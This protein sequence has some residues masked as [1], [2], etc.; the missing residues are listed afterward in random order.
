MRIPDFLRMNDWNIRKFSVVVLSLFVAYDGAFLTNE[1]LFKV[2]I[3]PQ[4]L[5]FIVLTFIPGF[6]ILRILKVHSIDRTTN[7]LLAVGLS[8]SF[9]MI[10]G[11]ILNQFLPYL[12]IEKPITTYPLFYSFN[13]AIVALL[14]ISYF[15]DRNFRGE[16]QASFE[17]D[18]SPS[19]L[20]L[21]LLP[22]LGIF[23][24]YFM[25]FYN[26]N[27]I[28]LFLLLLIS[29]IPLLVA[30]NKISENTFPFL[31]FAV[32]ISILYHVNLISTYLW[33]FDI[34]FH[35]H[36]SVQVVENG[37]WMLNLEYSDPLLLF[38]ILAPIYSILC[39]LSLI[40][41]FKIVFPFIFSLVPPTLYLVYNRADFGDLKLDSKLVLLSAFVFV[42]YYGFFKDMPDKQ[43]I[44]EFFLALILM[45]I[46]TKVPSRTIVAVI[47]SFSLITSHYGVSY[48][49]MLSLIF[50]LILSYL[51]N[52]KEGENG[53]L[54]LNFVLLFSTIAV[55]WYMY[56]ASGK[57]FADI[58]G[59]G[60]HIIYKVLELEIFKPDY[61]SG[62][63]YLAL[64]T[65]SI[66]WQIYKFVYVLLQLFIFIGIL[67]LLASIINGRVRNAEIA[68]LSI[69]FY[70]LLAFQI[71]TTYGMGFD[72]VLQITL[73]LLSPFAVIGCISI[74]KVV[75]RV[76]RNLKLKLTIL[77]FSFSAVKL[78]AIFLMVFFL[79]NSGFIFA[80]VGDT[81]PPYCIA[82]NKSTWERW[83]VFSQAEV[84]GALWLKDHN[85]ASKVSTL[86]LSLAKDG[87]IL[88]VYYRYGG[89]IVYPKISGDFIFF[90]IYTTEL[91]SNTLIYFCKMVT[92]D[93]KLPYMFKCTKKYIDL[94]KTT[95]YRKVLLSKA[96]RVYINQ[97]SSIYY[98]S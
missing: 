57:K 91:P 75:R 97:D 89:N 90:N 60:I 59:I 50:A 53:P 35:A 95:F 78:F 79:L 26:I 98:I 14:I 8:L 9:V 77:N 43:H 29:V 11:F 42:F 69:A 6:I 2:P 87:M 46:V 96:F 22:F 66:T 1:F 54:T 30:F 28:N 44:S 55:G 67:R 37:V 72:R 61:R 63:S 18:I 25:T 33:S 21:A 64:K 3:L 7:F 4:L 51:L 13:L 17:I 39:D 20:F 70:S 15:R 23:G 27:T 92:K 10:F 38:S 48:V 65:P 52:K 74:L 85:V 88:S 34:F 47:L 40:W 94:N 86:P 45:L 68:Y 80:V 56:V 62:I 93:N 58:T 49:F 83:H 5:G 81:L 71:F 76:I 41:F 32:S 19:L 31:I 16:Y 73:T 24:A 84:N 36:G 82:L 12:G